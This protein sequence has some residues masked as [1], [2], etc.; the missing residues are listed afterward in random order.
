MRTRVASAS[1]RTLVLAVLGIALVY[2]LALWLLLVSPKRAEAS[3]LGEDLAAAEL[4]L[5]E[6]RAA[7]NR[8]AG[9]SVRV[10]DVLRLAKAMPGSADQAG[11]VLE[12]SRAAEP[13]G[14]ELRSITPQ[15]PAAGAGGTTMIPVEVQVTGRYA[16]IVR[17]LERVRTLVT[18]R[19]GR[20]RAAGRLLV[21]QRA[22]LGESATAG[23]PALDATV[24]LHAYVYDGPVSPEGDDAPEDE[25]LQPTGSRAAAGRT[26]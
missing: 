20:L 26:P 6:A 17:F 8:P 4:E 1:T 22:E 11:L 23:F 14:V 5:A 19:D 2:A 13:T 3:R 24:T 12:I 16:E 18:V 21:V 25:E 7:S 10:S 15:L 9:A